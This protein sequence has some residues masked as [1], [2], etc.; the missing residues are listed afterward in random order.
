MT[1]APP[2]A[3]IPASEPVTPREH[4]T[5]GCFNNIVKVNGPVVAAWAK[6]LRAVPS[7]RLLLKAI[8]LADPETRAGVIATFAAAGVPPERIEARGPSPRPLFMAEMAD[9]DI[10]L[11]P[12]PY[13]GSTTTL[14]C[15]W[16]GVPVVTLDPPDGD[17][18]MAT[19]WIL[20]MLGLTDLV[21]PTPDAYEATAIALA[22]D[23]D[24]RRA[25]RA[26]LRDRVAAS[27]L[28]DGR[29]YAREIEWMI[30]YRF[31]HPWATRKAEA[32]AARRDPTT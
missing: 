1:Y 23:P 18:R 3:A 28:R 5:F 7:S 12:F 4:V 13:G 6:I 24:G 21:C 10:A 2:S 30:R 20:R 15:L 27:S 11:D 19:P 17:G 26:G 9:V 14:D 22:A 16:M 8:G 32:L 29:R 25:L 31:W